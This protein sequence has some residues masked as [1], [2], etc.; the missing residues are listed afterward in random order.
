[1]ELQEFINFNMVKS[2]PVRQ[3]LMWCDIQKYKYEIKKVVKEWMLASCWKFSSSFW[4]C[5][6]QLTFLETVTI[7]L[8]WV[9]GLTELI[10]KWNLDKKLTLIYWSRLGRSP[11]EGNGNTFQ[12]FCL[13]NLMELGAWVAT[14]HGVEKIQTWLSN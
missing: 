4:T 10:M 9:W 1:M 6:F 13:G 2:L 7:A 3:E 11:G 8:G 12:Y 5:L 14:V